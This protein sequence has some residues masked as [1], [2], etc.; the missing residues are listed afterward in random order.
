MFWVRSRLLADFRSTQCS[1][2]VTLYEN[3]RDDDPSLQDLSPESIDRMK[4]SFR[5]RQNLHR[6]HSK[7]IIDKAD[8]DG[9]R[10]AYSGIE[11][12]NSVV[13]DRTLSPSV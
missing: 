6:A 12:E 2:L 3:V 5:N 1:D 11:F 8:I 13:V 9:S 10:L 4:S 7:I